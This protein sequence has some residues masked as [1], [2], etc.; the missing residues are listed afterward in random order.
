[1]VGYH[2]LLRDLRLILKDNLIR[3]LNLL[4]L[5]QYLLLL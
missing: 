5:L 1:M 3:F 2:I 4:L